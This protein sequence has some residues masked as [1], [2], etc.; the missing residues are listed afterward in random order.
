MINNLTKAPEYLYL[1]SNL[2]KEASQ[3]SIREV[4]D[5]LTD[6]IYFKDKTLPYLN[7]K[8]IANIN[9]VDLESLFENTIVLAG[10]RESNLVDKHYKT[11]LVQLSFQLGF[12]IKRLIPNSSSA[13]YAKNKM[14]WLST[15]D[16]RVETK[17]LQ[18]FFN[19]AVRLVGSPPPVTDT[20][21]SSEV[22]FWDL[23]E[24]S[25]ILTNLTDLGA[26]F[27]RFMD[28]Y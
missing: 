17:L 1:D 25:Y 9:V 8:N 12:L 27:K 6:F 4:E 19:Q 16:V 24:I 26:K 28:S 23:D 14:I 11:M 15:I 2:L 13:E 3:E 22:Y 18:R 5:V 20:T 21:E 7:R 10:G